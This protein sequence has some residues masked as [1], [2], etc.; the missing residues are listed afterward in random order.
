METMESRKILF[1]HIPKCG[2]TNINEYIKNKYKYYE[3]YI[4]RIL[5]YDLHKYNEY[6]I[7]SVIRDPIKRLISLYFY[8]TNMINRLIKIN[9]LN[10]FQEGNWKK[11][12][13]LYKKYNI[14]TITSFLNNYKLFYENEV[15]PFI[16]DL[17]KYN[18]SINMTIFYLVGFLPQYLF[19]CDDDDNL[20]VDEV[21]NI[22]NCEKFM[23]NKFGIS[24]GKK[25]NIHINSNDNYYNYTTPENIS[26]IKEI[27]IK[28][29]KILF[30]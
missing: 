19:I 15:K 1:V 30:K 5:K 24:L 11:L 27:Y 6:Y 2:G 22:D 7:F 13:L 20:L 3:W 17:E 12:H 9:L 29:Y 23:L 10:D 21:V 18:N 14:E 8:Q 4:H 28:D 26:D 25:I 16:L